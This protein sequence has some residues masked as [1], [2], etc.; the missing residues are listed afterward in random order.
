[1][2]PTNHVASERRQRHVRTVITLKII[3]VVITYECINNKVSLS[4]GQQVEII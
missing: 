1:M 3:S 4:R 2:V